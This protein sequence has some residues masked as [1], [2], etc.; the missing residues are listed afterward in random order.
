MNE[1]EKE[2]HM[3]GSEEWARL[4]LVTSVNQEIAALSQDGKILI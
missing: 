3:K 2:S 1:A 4:A